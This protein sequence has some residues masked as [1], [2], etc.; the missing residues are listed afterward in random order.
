MNNINDDELR[1]VVKYYKPKIAVAASIILAVGIAVAAGIIGYHN[2]ML[3]QKPIPVDTAYVI[4]DYEES[5]TTDVFRFDHT[6]I[7]KVLANCRDTITPI[8]MQATPQR[9]LLEK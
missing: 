6:P 7:N 3:P 1:F 9:V 8:S 2:Y 5:D 4:E